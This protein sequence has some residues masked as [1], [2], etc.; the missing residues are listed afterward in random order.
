MVEEIFAVAEDENVK[1]VK[2][3]KDEDTSSVVEEA[4]VD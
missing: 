3:K 2:D 1:F 4:T